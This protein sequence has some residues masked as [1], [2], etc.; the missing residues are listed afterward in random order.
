MSMESCDGKDAG[1]LVLAS[2][3]LTERLMG[4]VDSR[5]QASIDTLPNHQPV[6]LSLQ[7][8]ADTGT[9]LQLF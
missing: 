2:L 8:T 7:G 6:S 4:I 1:E 3:T 9:L 5:L